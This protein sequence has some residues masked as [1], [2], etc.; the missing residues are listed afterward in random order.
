M[1]ESN[2]V[3]AATTPVRCA[4]CGERHAVHWSNGTWQCPDCSTTMFIVSTRT[5]AQLD[6]PDDLL[7]ESG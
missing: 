3:A 7:P 6:S 5:D 1:P 2:E 4:G